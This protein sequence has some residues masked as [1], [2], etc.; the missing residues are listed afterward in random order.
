MK[1][2]TKEDIQKYGTEDEKKLLKEERGI[3]LFVVV[4]MGEGFSEIKRILG[5]CSDSEKGLENYNKLKKRAE[6]GKIHTFNFHLDEIP[7]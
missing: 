4:E 1:K 2:L 7:F 3:E 6:K 5:V